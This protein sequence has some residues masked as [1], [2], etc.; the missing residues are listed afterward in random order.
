MRSPGW[1]LSSALVMVG[2]AC[3]DAAPVTSPATMSA[4]PVTTV[5]V[6][7]GPAL[8]VANGVATTAPSAAP[9]SGGDGGADFYS[10]TADPD[11]IAVPQANCCPNGRLEAVNRQSA[12]AYKA[13]LVCGGK[14]RMCPQYRVLDKREPLC[15]NDS[16]RCEM[17]QLEMIPCGTQNAHSCPGSSQC[18]GSGHC[19]AKP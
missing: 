11:C 10:C 9:P 18:D 6:D 12:G 8:S 4:V 14:H 13:S 15:N 3:N 7:G 2:P 17:V 19:A 1:V 5:V 16:H